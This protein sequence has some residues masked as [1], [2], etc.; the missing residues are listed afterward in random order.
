MVC[1]ASAHMAQGTAIR[2]SIW[3]DYDMAHGSS[4]MADKVITL[5]D[6]HSKWWTGI[7]ANMIKAN[8]QSDRYIEKERKSTQYLGFVF[9]HLPLIAWWTIKWVSHHRLFSSNWQFMMRA[10]FAQR[11]ACSISHFFGTTITR[12]AQHSPIVGQIFA[13]HNM[14]NCY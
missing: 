6:A 4:F 8:R 2:S 14:Y 7:S 12:P 1:F 10:A 9:V 11:V 13:L 3:F 5:F